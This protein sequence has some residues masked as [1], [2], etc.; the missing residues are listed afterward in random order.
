MEL[1]ADWI[2][3]ESAGAPLQ[4]YLARPATGGGTPLP[5]VVVIQEIWGPDEHIQDVTERFATAGYVALAPDLYSRGGRPEA[6]AVNRV[7]EA[8]AFLDRLPP[9]TWGNPAE[10]DAALQSMPSEERGR[11]SS[12]LGAL[13]SGGPR[14]GQYLADLCAAVAYLSVH[15]ACAGRGIGAVGFCMG[16]SLSALLA[17]TEPGLSAAAIFYGGSP[18]TEQ[19]THLHCPLIGFYGGNDPRIT[20][21]VP[22]FEAAVRSANGRFE[23]HVYAGAPHAFFNDTRPSYTPEAARDAWAATLG[24]FAGHLR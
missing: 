17:C 15:P 21:G 22:A 6:L 4:A 24:F 20:A 10:R 23:T 5:A 11:I 8:K 2:E 14:M 9:G 7:A 18:P 16:G 3:F 19:A 12:T 13:F 1:H